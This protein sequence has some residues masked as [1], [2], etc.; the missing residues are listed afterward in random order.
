MGETIVA[1]A[2]RTGKGDRVIPFGISL[3]TLGA[4]PA[5]AWASGPFLWPWGAA[6]AL[7]LGAVAAAAF[8]RWLR[9]LETVRWDDGSRRLEFCRPG[10][11]LTVDLDAVDRL[12]V[13]PSEARTVLFAR[14]RRYTLSHRLVRVEGLLARFRA[15][16]PDLFPEPVAPQTLAS[17]PTP[18][19][20]LGLLAAGTALAGAFLGAWNPVIGEGLAASAALVVARTLWFVPRGFVVSPGTLVVLYVLRRRTWTGPAA[21]HTDEYAAGGVQFFRVHAVWGTQTVV[22]D[23]SSLV[24]PLRPWAPWIREQ[25]TPSSE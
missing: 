25:W 19:V 3:L 4:A 12:V 6:V 11:R 7:G 16:R 20:V 15:L 14:G 23:E 2:Y 21:V 9:A 17:S 22:L 18:F 8:A 13:V 24:V 10:R 5:L 1:P